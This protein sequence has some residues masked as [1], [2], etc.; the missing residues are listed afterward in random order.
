[1]WFVDNCSSGGRRRRR[2]EPGSGVRVQ[3]LVGKPLTLDVLLMLL[4]LLFEG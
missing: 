2:P 3:D 4:M 1:M